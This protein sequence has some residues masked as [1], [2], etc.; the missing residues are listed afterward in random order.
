M[1]TLTPEE[2]ERLLRTLEVDRQF[3]DAVLGAL[4]YE[5]IVDA[6]RELTREVRRL[7]RAMEGHCLRDM[8][9]EKR[10]EE[11]RKLLEKI[12]PTLEEEANDMVQYHLKQKGIIMMTMPVEFPQ[13]WVDIYGTNMQYTVVGYTEAKVS[14]EFI[15]RASEKLGI[16][17]SKNRDKFP[18]KVIRVVYCIRALP[19]AA[20][21]AGELGIWLLEE[22]RELTPFPG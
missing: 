3:R 16:I 9:W 15:A 18:G 22:E 17:I 6:L 13:G 5:T 1:E 19:S 11:F 20:E 10:E 14:K 4:G 12:G 8:E 2:K 21:R 7:R